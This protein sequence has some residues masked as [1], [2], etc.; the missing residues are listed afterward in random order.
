MKIS[1]LAHTPIIV[2][3]V[4]WVA[5]LLPK[6]LFA[7][8][9]LL[10]QLKFDHIA[11]SQLE[12]LGHVNDIISD[13]EGYMW[14]A[15]SKGV[16]RYDG[17]QLNIFRSDG[18]QGSLPDPWVYQLLV[19]HNNVLWVL[20]HLGPCLFDSVEV[21]FKCIDSI[22]GD[23]PSDFLRIFEDS[24]HRLWL[25]SY[26]GLFIVDTASL[27]ISPAPL[28]KA[29][30]VVV[31][32]TEDSQ[33]NI[34][35]GHQDSGIT[36]LSPA[37]EPIQH[38]SVEQG[39][40]PGNKISSLM[41]DKNN[42]LWIGLRD[43]GVAILKHGAHK[44]E[45]FAHNTKEKAR[46]V[47]DITEDQRGLI[48]IGDGTGVNVVDPNDMSVQSH[49]YT[50]GKLQSP[51]NYVARAL[52]A[53]KV[54]GVWVG[55]F[56]GGVDRIDQRAS[57]FMSYRHDSN[58]TNSLPDG[59]VLATLQ[60]SDGTIWVGA[61][62]GLAKFHRDKGNFTHFI[63]DENDPEGL[64]GSTI[65]AIEEG[66]QGELWLGIWDKGLN[67]RDP[68][69]GKYRH[70]LPEP[71]NPNSLLGRE[72]WGLLYDSQERLW[73][74]TEK[75]VSR[76]RP[77]TDD[78]QRYPL[79][80][81][82]GKPI[83]SLY[84]RAIYEDKAGA[85]W[86]SSFAGLQKLD[87]K[88]G[89]FKTYE[90]D[91]ANPQSIS[92]NLV[93]LVFE[94]SQ[95]RLWVGT[96]GSGLNLFNRDTETF[97]RFGKDSGLPD[98]SITNILEG[99]NG[100]LWLTTYHGIVHFTPDRGV[101]RHYTRAQGL[102]GNLY[103]RRSGSMLASGEL[104]MGSSEGL[105]L[106]DSAKLDIQGAEFGTVFNGLRVMNNAVNIG[107]D[108]GILA[109][110]LN[111]AGKI[112]LNHKQ[113]IFSL[114]FAG[115]HFGAPEDVV[116]RYRLL[117]FDTG[118]QEVMNDL[119]ATY[120]NLDAGTY[121]FEVNSGTKNR[122]NSF[123]RSLTIEILPPPWLT[124]WAKTIYALLLA[125]ILAAI[126]VGQRNR[127]IRASHR[128]KQE[129]ELVVKLREVEKLKDNINRAL[130]QKVELRTRE[131]EKEKARLEKAHAQLEEL[132]D[133]LASLTITDQLTGL[134]NRR[135]LEQT[136][137]KDI[138][139]VNRNAQRG[140]HSASLT[141]VLFDIDNFKSVNDTHGHNAGD[142]VLIQLARLLKQIVRDSDYVVRWGGEEFIIVMRNGLDAGPMTFAER[143]RKSV[144]DYSFKISDDIHLK[145]SVSVGLVKYPFDPQHPTALSWECVVGLA[146]QGLYKAKSSGKNRC[147]SVENHYAS[148]TESELK[149]I[150][151]DADFDQAI[152][153]KRVVFSGAKP[154]DK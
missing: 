32:I 63:Y 95:E 5:I 79:T 34:W 120:T 147:I 60:A 118:W 97:T 139:R 100:D 12:P 150:I 17:H 47:W 27:T 40:L 127:L 149:A 22:P 58:N 26:G 154:P 124:W 90:H 146:D 136:V 74:A 69:T 112:T 70:Y 138:A 54:G 4:F 128:L 102:P 18:K 56:P 96:D 88:T 81:D 130:D 43:Q 11:Q 39:T 61:G 94:D 141:F 50:E 46:E 57:Q 103:N 73:I 92:S 59:G 15:A 24:Q 125:G 80:D 116:Y 110:D 36:Q 109:S 151:N 1:G 142:Q 132:N 19:T 71:G 131:L 148:W 28:G 52:Y 23:N 101:I 25:S 85:I 66:R 10:P 105:V 114:S 55:Y 29:L 76:Y 89:R 41:F 135:Y 98:L 106:F 62:F 9:N 77:A 68:I 115:L 137:K 3:L 108:S 53:D 2:F 45:Y 117:G 42:S 84:T 121:I 145:R 67:R 93:L 64:S 153:D 107:D 83:E 72:P 49:Q 31:Y 48:W 33:G 113:N 75:G 51:G 37:M 134:Y 7:R 143:L 104:I 119:S 20:T 38:F 152:K 129:Q 144:S 30:G 14:F 99:N 126:Y 6:A 86:V 78:F 91:P 21:K 122:W 8:Q 140:N 87:P 44:A 123:V 35:L 16:A 65:L 133:K 13:A 82:D 111:Y